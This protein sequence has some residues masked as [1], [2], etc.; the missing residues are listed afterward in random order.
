MTQNNRE[1]NWQHKLH[2][3]NEKL[4]G[5]P[6]IG[7]TGKSGS[8]ASAVSKILERMGGFVINADAL[9]HELYLLDGL[10]YAPVV[11]AFSKEIL[12]GAGEIDRKK[13]GSLVFADP[14]KMKILEGIIH[15]LVIKCCLEY[16]DDIETSRAYAF[17]VVDAPMLI[18]SHCH[19]F[20]TTTWLIVAE[21][22]VRIARIVK[23][24]HI[25]E[26]AAQMRLSARVDDGLLEKNAD[27]IIENNGTLSALEDTVHN[28]FERFIS[29]MMV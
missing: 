23:R 17:V 3:L 29:G 9:A 13:L 2:A 12:N 20:C 8:G 10:A 15:P 1:M 28:A 25:S 27:F 7:V 26:A 19:Q 5:L 16:I 21:N 6:V 24:D 18:E 22:D 11:D 4:T 14:D